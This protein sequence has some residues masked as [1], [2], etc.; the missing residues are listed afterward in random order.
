MHFSGE[1]LM[2]HIKNLKTKSIDL[3][4]FANPLSWAKLC[5][6]LLPLE[7]HF[8]HSKISLKLKGGTSPKPLHIVG[9]H[10]SSFTRKGVDGPESGV[11]SGARHFCEMKMN[12]A[13]R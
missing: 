5:V 2:R 6:K 12:G 4:L 11:G 10:M 1:Q 9:V 13:V 7:T 3:S 8:F